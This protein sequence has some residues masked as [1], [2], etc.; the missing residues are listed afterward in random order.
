MLKTQNKLVATEID[1]DH[2]KQELQR[3]RE[4]EIRFSSEREFLQK[5]RQNQALLLQNLE[6]IKTNIEKSEVEGKLK[7]ENNL[8][9]L[10]RECSALRKRLQEE[11]DRFR[12]VISDLEQEK[13][14]IIQTIS[15]KD[16]VI[17]KLKNNLRDLEEDLK[18]KCGEIENLIAKSNTSNS[19][20]LENEEIVSSANQ[21]KRQIEEQN[22]EISSLNRE[23]DMVREH[24]EQY[25]HMSEN[26]EKELR[27]SNKTFE[28]TKQELSEQIVQLKRTESDLLEK[29]Q[30][31]ERDFMI[32]A[33]MNINE[34]TDVESLK[35]ELTN[36]LSI[37]STIKSESSTLKNQYTQICEDLR[38]AEQKYANEMILHSADIQA[39]ASL[40]EEH[41]KL[42]EEYN[43]FKIS[44]ESTN[45]ILAKHQETLLA[46]ENQHK[47]EKH[48]LE[49]QIKDLQSHN[50]TLYSQIETLS[51]KLAA[52][53]TQDDHNISF[54]DDQSKSVEE[55]LRIIKFLRKEK[56]IALSKLDLMN[57]ESV[58]IQT[59]N[60]ILQKK[61]EKLSE[62]VQTTPS[63]TQMM[64][65]TTA[66]H[67]ELLRKLETIN[68]ITDSNRI[69]REERDSLSVRIK[70]LSDQ[71]TKLQ[72]ELL[73]LK[74]KDQELSMKLETLANENTSLRIEVTRWRQR[75]N[76][77]IE[78]ANKSS[79]EDVKRLI[80]EKENL[81]KVSTL[82][83]L[84]TY[85]ICKI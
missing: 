48:D 8:S 31:M 7:L 56:E 32:Q 80:Q 4:S 67:E 84:R 37:I 12:I 51:S 38:I 61:I 54:A 59:E 58:R 65:A 35:K 42:L 55:L 71:V 43:N 3:L 17:A 9:E 14:N 77:L 45:N 44:K 57:N 74:E 73:P 66:K 23:L 60:K 19:A 21:L 79:P 64:I 34:E 85:T 10:N 16:D 30:S 81:C 70:D 82:D 26:L 63:E 29:I 72:S 5:E 68:A 33:K 15:E 11:E 24:A 18:S 49:L 46:L 76:L 27:N 25:C 75:T 6:S 83:L 13:R 1:C 39:F 20:P 40:K 52:F 53:T 62:S 22:I 78:R 36:S 28:A 69:L 41:Q 2:F 47:Q 50:S